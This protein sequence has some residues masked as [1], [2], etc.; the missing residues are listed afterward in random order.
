MKVKFR[1]KVYWAKKSHT[2]P[3]IFLYDNFIKW[4]FDDMNLFLSWSYFIE[5]L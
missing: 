3:Y 4:L 5:N 2:G 1:D